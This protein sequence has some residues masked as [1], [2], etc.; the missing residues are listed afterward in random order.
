MEKANPSLF[1]AEF[2]RLTFLASIAT[3]ATEKSATKA[4][5]AFETQAQTPT[6]KLENNIQLDTRQKKHG[7]EQN[8]SEQNGISAAK[9]AIPITSSQLDNHSSQVKNDI[10]IQKINNI[11]LNNTQDNNSQS[12]KTLN[13][14]K[15]NPSLFTVSSGSSSNQH[16]IL[17]LVPTSTSTKTSVTQ[18]VPSHPLL[19]LPSG[20]L[21]SKTTTLSQQQ[22]QRLAGIVKAPLTTNMASSTSTTSQA[23]NPPLVISSA[24]ARLQQNVVTNAGQTILLPANF[25]GMISVEF[26]ITLRQ[27]I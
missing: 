14:G 19:T 15:T 12:A 22:L 20:V 5:K 1:E 2:N 8:Y 13:P 16:N 26:W 17:Q 4:Q 7:E 6:T 3:G 21:G 25:A 9:T 18:S 23:V 11:L 24:Q 10:D 27:F